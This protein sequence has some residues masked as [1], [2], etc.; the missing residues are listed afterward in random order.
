MGS[1]SRLISAVKA[2]Q[3]EAFERL[4]TRVLPQLT[5]YADRRCGPYAGVDDGEDIAL[6]V[7]LSL[8]RAVMV[9]GRF[10]GQL[11]DRQSLWRVLHVL[12]GQKLQRC[13]RDGTRKKRDYRKTL[14]SADLAGDVASWD[15]GEASCAE[16][17]ARLAEQET[18]DQWLAPL[19]EEQRLL[20]GL[21]LMGATNREIADHLGMSL[22]T[23]E[24]ELSEIRSVWG[25]R[26][27]AVT[28]K[29]PPR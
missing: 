16:P 9:R 21:K 13:R 7:I 19:T 6:G 20:V 10:L 27:Q 5:S 23:V 29:P 18:M 3:E 22:R 1:V 28:G 11:S 25:E 2:G 12:T 24:R 8:W 4:C 15:F 26:Y 14:R 17:G